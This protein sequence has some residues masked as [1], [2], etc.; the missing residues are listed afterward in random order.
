MELVYSSDPMP[1]FEYQG[2][3]AKSKS[4]AMAL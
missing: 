4:L 3:S 2:L 1:I